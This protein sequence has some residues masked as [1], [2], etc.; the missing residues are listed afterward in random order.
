M[1]NLRQ[2]LQQRLYHDHDCM[3]VVLRNHHGSNYM[4]FVLKVLFVRDR[5]T[6]MLWHPYGCYQT[7]EV[8]LPRLSYRPTVVLLG[9]R[10]RDRL[11]VVL[12][13][14]R[15]PYRPSV[16]SKEGRRCYCPTVM[17]QG[18]GGRDRLIVVLWNHRGPYSPTVTLKGVVETIV[19][20]LS[21]GTA[22]CTIVS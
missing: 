2:N 1:F 18:R 6:I 16:T 3:L 22:V 17:L 19:P 12:W 20:Q 5:P 4:I 21:L 8:A 15:G 7:T 9:R 13:H 11:I 10:D 14:H